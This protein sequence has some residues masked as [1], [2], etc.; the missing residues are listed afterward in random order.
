MTHHK[1]KSRCTK[2]KDE[3]VEVVEGEASTSETFRCHFC[4]TQFSRSHIMFKVKT[5]GGFMI[6]LVFFTLGSQLISLL[7]Y[8]IIILVQNGSY[9]NKI[10]TINNKVLIHF[11]SYPA[12]AFK[13]T[14]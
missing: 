10:V 12:S 11:I 1:D 8:N 9:E 7:K 3:E 13:K 14:Y 4:A 2:V 6:Y 5:L